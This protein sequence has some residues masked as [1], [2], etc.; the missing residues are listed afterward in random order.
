MGNKYSCN[1][2]KI[3]NRAELSMKIRMNMM[4]NNSYNNLNIYDIM[5]SKNVDIYKYGSK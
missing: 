4:A 3:Y 2:T 5:R 1:V